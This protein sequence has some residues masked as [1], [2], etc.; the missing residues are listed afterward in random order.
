MYSKCHESAKVKEEEPKTTKMQLCGSFEDS[1]VHLCST[2]LKGLEAILCERVLGFLSDRWK[3][4]I[5][6]HHVMY[7]KLSGSQ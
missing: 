4:S 1:G 2:Y 6:I 5:V 3:K 7:R